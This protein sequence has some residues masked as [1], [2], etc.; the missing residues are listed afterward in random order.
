[1]LWGT[2]YNSSVS[3]PFNVRNASVTYAI[4]TF[5]PALASTTNGTQPVACI[6]VGSYMRASRT[7]VAQNA[8][9]ATKDSTCSGDFGSSYGAATTL[10]ATSFA[11]SASWADGVTFAFNVRDDASSS[12][13]VNTVAIAA[14]TGAT[15]PAM[16]V[17]L[18]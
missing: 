2:K 12:F 17:R 8:S 18:N 10:E 7:T 9:A 15:N 11:G 14:T 5:A 6:R 4:T 3:S 16:C 1:M 13:Y